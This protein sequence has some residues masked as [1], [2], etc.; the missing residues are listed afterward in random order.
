[1]N[2]TSSF[3]RLAALGVFPILIS[4]LVAAAQPLVAPPL[5]GAESFA[6]L[7]GAAVSNSGASTFAG[8]VG[9]DAAGSITGIT[10]AMLAPG[11][12][13][14][15]GDAVAVQAHHSAS[16]AYSHL[17][18]LAC[19][20]AND[21]TGQT[22]G[23]GTL[24]SL[25]TGVYCFDGDAPLAGTLTL[26]GT[27][28]WI[29]QVGGSLT[30]A[31]GA[32]VVAPAVVP[33][34]TCSG[35]KVFWQVGD[36][37]PA[38]PALTTIGAGATLVGNILGLGDI[39]MATGA[40]LDGRAV[41]IGEIAGATLSGGNVTLA[42]NVVNACSYGT[43]LPTAAPFKVTGGG[44]INVP[45]D[46]TETNPEASGS[47]FAN[48]GFNAQPGVAGAATTGTFNYVNHVVAGNRHV[49][50]P[51]TDVDVL[52]LNQDATARTV[53]F[54]GTCDAFL[55]A[56][57]FSVM[58]EDN[59]EPPFNDRFGV[60]FVS[61]GTVVEDRAIRRIRAGNIQFHTAALT[62]T[63]NAETVRHGQTMR[64]A[65]RL[66]RDATRT[67]A[68]A[69]VVL[70]MPGGQLLSWTG[71]ALVSGLAPLQRNFV[72]VDFDGQ[73][74][75]LQ[76]PAGT[77]AGTYTWMSALTEAGT[78]NLLSPIAERSFAVAP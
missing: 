16:L 23:Q 55:P 36:N 34:G 14:H 7:S 74:L 71:N 61:N 2:V 62:T 21:K 66:R 51:V 58:V 53:R 75:Q 45:S 42:A 28:P 60:T 11:S 69:Y 3:L 29:F 15:E 49:N 46:P 78:L 56:C 68:D 33:P 32:S 8:D 12:S 25:A 20:P 43:A 47:G 17:A 10:P 72:P 26:T 57:T 52:A 54:S 30:V 70:R 38:T 64:L 24:Q 4:P 41:A 44:G 35:S 67:P 63:V 1:M 73:I 22:L 19:S 59:G 13:L 39:T 40:S 5:G 18:A 76:V 77:P 31:A 6:V 9:A 50:G 48:Y 37:A 65:A 27:G